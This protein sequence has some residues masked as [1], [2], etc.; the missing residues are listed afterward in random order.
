[1]DLWSP[2][3][4]LYPR[5]LYIPMDFI[6]KREGYNDDEQKKIYKFVVFA[7]V[8]WLAMITTGEE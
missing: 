7:R 2:S 4:S 1:M 8:G 3:I 6:R 5:H